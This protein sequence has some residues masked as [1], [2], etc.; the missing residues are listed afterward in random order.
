MLGLAFE[1]DATIVASAPLRTD[2]ACFVGFVR[3]RPGRTLPGLD[4]WRADYGWTGPYLPTESIARSAWALESAVK[5]GP[6]PLP[7][8]IQIGDEPERVDLPEGEVPI[9]N[10]V[11]LI[12]DSTEGVEAALDRE[13]C[14]T[15]RALQPGVLHLGRQPVL[16]FPRATVAVGRR[17]RPPHASDA[18]S[19]PA[20]DERSRGSRSRWRKIRKKRRSI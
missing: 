8:Q 14:L 4:R 9:G 17:A 2:I 1:Q 19:A 18:A 16:G 6:G 20:R 5:F 3:R 10:V 11:E 15:L 7:W 13:G 12:N